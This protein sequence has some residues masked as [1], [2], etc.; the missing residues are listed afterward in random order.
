MSSA[1]AERE[2]APSGAVGLGLPLL[3]APT[4]LLPPAAVVL[5]HAL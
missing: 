2:S 1:A 5:S 3:A 4:V